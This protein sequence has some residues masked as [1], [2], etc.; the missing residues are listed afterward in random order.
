MSEFNNNVLRTLVQEFGFR[1]GK[2]DDF[3]FHPQDKRK[4]KPILTKRAVIAIKEKREFR[5]DMVTVQEAAGRILVSGWM[6]DD[7]TKRKVWTTG[8]ANPGGRSVEGSHPVAM[9][10]KRWKARAVLALECGEGSGIYSEEEFNDEYLKEA[11]AS[12]PP[13]PPQEARQEPITPKPAGEWDDALQAR[14]DAWNTA[15]ATISEVTGEDRAKFE[16]PLFLHCTKFQGN[17]GWV[18]PKRDGKAVATMDDLF[19]CAKDPASYGKWCGS[20]YGKARDVIQLLTSGEEAVLEIPDPAD[21]KAP[22]EV[23]LVLR[24]TA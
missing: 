13:E 8:E 11:R 10:E 18:L 2:W 14:K 17:N 19:F 6:V 7:K 4:M 1:E 23:A 15:C 9:A 5:I 24:P 16:A 3:Y 20:A 21:M 22:A 12:R